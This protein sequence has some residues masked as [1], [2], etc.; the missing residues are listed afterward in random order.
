MTIKEALKYGYK[1][2][3]A[4]RLLDAEALLSFALKKDKEFLF[5]YPEKDVSPAVWKKFKRLIERRCGNEPTAYLTRHKEFFGLDF[6]VDKNTLIP[7]PET[8]MMAQ[9]AIDRIKNRES[10]IG[11]K[12]IILID[13]GAGSGYVPIAIAKNI[14]AKKVKFFAVDISSG[15]LKT[16]EKNAR[17]HKVKI[18]FLQSDLLSKLI[19]NSKFLLPDS[20]CLITANLPYLSRKI[21]QKAGPDVKNFEP[22]TA[23]VSAEN[24][25]KHY[26]LLLQ[27]IKTAGPKQTTALLEIDPSQKNKISKL[28]KKILP[29]ARLVIKKDLSQKERL[30][31]A[32]LSAG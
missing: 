31:I 14:N 30:V 3:G 1:E 21:W 29:A 16:A 24:G 18:K 5:T 4:S 13:V 32:D 17:R 25:L 19:H 20:Y 15:A 28:G 6:L 10:G 9:E 12:K 7:R 2:L 23:L 8:E 27:Q 22:K 11:N 26:R